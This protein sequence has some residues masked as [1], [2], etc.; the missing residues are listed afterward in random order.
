MLII[1]FFDK[2]IVAPAVR[3][4]PFTPLSGNCTV[5][6]VRLYVIRM[7]MHRLPGTLYSLRPK[8][9]VTLDPSIRKNSG[10]LSKRHVILVELNELFSC[11]YNIKYRR[12]SLNAHNR[13]FRQKNRGT[14][15]PPSAVHSPIRELYRS[16]CTVIRNTYAYA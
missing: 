9:I 12:T 15:R 2:K 16:T 1:E 6:H 8:I 10:I 3:R 7:H 14:R 4:L 11:M 13:V 5:V